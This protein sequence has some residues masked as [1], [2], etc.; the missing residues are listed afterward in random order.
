MNKDIKI[1]DKSIKMSGNAATAIRYK[2]VFNKDLLLS[3]SKMSEGNYDVEV[4]QELGFVMAKAAEGASFM[5]LTID[6]Y[7]TWL[8]QFEQIDVY[9]A[10]PDIVG[11]W[12]DTSKLSVNSKKKA[13]RSTGT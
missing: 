1:G 5:A 3:L 13:V 2:Q 8:E 4:V 11:L 9:Q 7:I 10:M 12:L 6:D